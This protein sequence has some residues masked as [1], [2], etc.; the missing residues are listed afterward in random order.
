MNILFIVTWYTKHDAPITAGIF[1][2]EMAKAM[3]KYCNVAIYWPSDSSLSRNSFTKYTEDGVITYRRGCGAS[4]SAKIK[5]SK[6]KFLFWRVVNHIRSI[7]RKNNWK[8]DIERI[9][10][11]FQPDIIHSHCGYLAGYVAALCTKRSKIPC[12]VTEHTPIEMMGLKSIRLKHNW[13]IAYKHSF[14]NICVSDDLKN[15]LIKYFPE[16]KFDVIYNGI[17]DPVN[18]EWVKLAESTKSIYK[19]GFV[20]AV[21][22]ASFYDQYIKGFQFLLPAIAQLKKHGINIYVHIVGGGTYL[23]YFKGIASDLEIND[24]LTFYGQC[25]KKTV[26][27]YVSQMDFGI[28]ASLFE[29]AGVSVEEMQ[30]LGKPVL[31]T[32]SGGANSLVRDF[33]AITVDK[34]SAEALVIGLE[35]MCA[36]YRNFDSERIRQFAVENFEMDNICKKYYELYKNIINNS[37]KIY[38]NKKVVRRK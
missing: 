27:N 17:N 38:G 2:Y 23:D 8:S 33:S 3:Q 7:G 29:S 18:S 21:I 16:C 14:A 30:L 36:E 37:K 34:G 20:N 24:R 6:I 11:E 32:K 19:A 12:I 35:K 22:V 28:S 15:K 4:P 5:S 31:V 26:Y 25:D 13:N 10:S 9:I 1:H